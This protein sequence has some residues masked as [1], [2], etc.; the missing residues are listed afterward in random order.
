MRTYKTSCPNAPLE[1][2]ILVMV[3]ILIGMDKPPINSADS[4]HIRRLVEA[5]NYLEIA[6]E[7]L[8]K[9]NAK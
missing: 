6:K 2:Q 3:G 8:A 1:A 7:E 4:E 9:E 5:F